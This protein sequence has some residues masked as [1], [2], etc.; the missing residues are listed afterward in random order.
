[1]SV[2]C[3]LCQ[4]SLVKKREVF[5]KPPDLYWT[6]E[7]CHYVYMDPERRLTPSEEKIR[8]DLHENV[9]SEGY[10]HFLAP[11][12]QAV[13]RWGQGEGLDY[14]CGPTAFLEKLLSEQGQAIQNYDLYFRDDRNL[15]A[16]Q[17]DFITCTEVIEHL[18][19]PREVFDFFTRALRP[20]GILILM[21]SFLTDKVDFD[22]WSYRR[23]KTH[24][25]FFAPES[26]EYIAREWGFEI[27][28]TKNPL[29]VMR[30]I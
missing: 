25:G 14:G 22:R 1:M 24:V 29:V 16:K 13:T 15:L 19:S 6:C 28:E 7:S 8:Y 9:E 30:K 3:L 21:T 5:A 23:E 26:L 12:V 2:P 4:S 20:Q 11:A 17:Y 18:Y 10:R 27:L